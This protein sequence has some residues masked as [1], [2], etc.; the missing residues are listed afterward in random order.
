MPKNK[1]LPQGYFREEDEEAMN[2]KKGSQYHNIGECG[3]LEKEIRRLGVKKF[4]EMFGNEFLEQF[5]DIVQEEKRLFPIKQKIKAQSILRH[6]YPLCEK[7]ENWGGVQD[8]AIPCPYDKEEYEKN[9]TFEKD[10]I[11]NPVPVEVCEKF[12]WKK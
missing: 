3:D 4:R 2:K 7:C 9:I 5:K 11:S 8:G 10:E 6:D 12:K 1:P